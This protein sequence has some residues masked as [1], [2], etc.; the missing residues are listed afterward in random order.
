VVTHYQ[1]TDLARLQKRTV[2]V[3]AM[4]QALGGFGLGATLSVGALLAVELSGT[5]AWSG[6]A[7]TLST[8]GSAVSA[9]PL[10]NLAYRAG[11]R[12]A[13]ASGAALAIAGAVFMILA[14]YLQSFP[15]EILALFMLG[16]GSAVSLQARFAAADIPIAGP[17]GKDLSM[18]VWATT[19]GAVIGPNLIAPGEALGLAIGMPHLAGPFLFTIAAQLSST[20]V[21]WFGLK[22]DPLLVAKEIAGL[23]AKRKNPGFKAAIEV[24]RER[25]MAGYAVL[26]IALSHMVM[27]SVMSMTPAHLHSS[28]HSL[29]DVGL[30]ISLH[31]AGMYALAPI[32]G[33]LT[34][35]LG[36]VRT[37]VLG[38]VTFLVSLGFA[39]FGQ[40][41]FLMVIIGLILLGLGWSASTVAGSAL[42]TEVLPTD[43]KT[44]VQG[45]SDS[46]MNLSGAFGGAISGTIL[47]VYTFG[48]LNAAALI[49][50]VFIV[51]ATSY[52]KRWRG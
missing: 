14:T 20:L 10:A 22:P 26:T 23:P 45:F 27:V 49:P 6:A 48:G 11:R 51:V 19:L 31:I 30:T 28:G 47:L 50:V 18:V 33:M 25:P 2:K 38:Q 5:T 36:P 29:A 13:L 52:S 16:A 15:V 37:I 7:A 46:L 21:F 34:D 44:K 43:E 17:R 3:L 24:I 32:F 4:G 42:L 39:G 41:N 9:I 12:I 35:K 8:L 1:P 40:D